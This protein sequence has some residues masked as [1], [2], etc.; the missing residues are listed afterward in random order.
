MRCSRCGSTVEADQPECGHCGARRRTGRLVPLTNDLPTC[1][2]CGHVGESV[3]YFSR[4]LHA[5]GLLAATLVTI[6]VLGAGGVV[7]YFLRRDHQICARCGLDFGTW[8]ERRLVTGGTPHTPEPEL[9]PSSSGEWL[10]R[11][12]GI[13]LLLVGVLLMVVSASSRDLSELFMGVAFTIGGAWLVRAAAA[14]RDLRRVQIV[15]ALQ[16]PV[17]RLASEQGGRLTASLVAAELGWSI[18]RS[19]KILDSLELSDALRVS[20]E[21]TDEG[22][23][24]Y[25]FRELLGDPGGRSLPR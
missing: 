11:F 16:R 18:A 7:Y 25:E 21:V 9:F 1:P 19:K 10:R 15:S 24:V 14:A 2:R 6:G 12:A 17:I 3:P 22:L 13:S 23:I 8:Q 20:S 4:G 5:G